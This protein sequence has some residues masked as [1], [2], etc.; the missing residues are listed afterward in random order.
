MVVMTQSIGFVLRIV[1]V[2]LLLVSVAACSAT[3]IAYGQADRLIL[4]RVDDLVSLT[5]EQED[6]L[7]ARID[8]HLDWHCRTQLPRY[9]QWLSSVRATLA[10]VPVAQGDVAGLMAEAEVFLDELLAEIAPTVAGLMLRLDDE[11]RRELFESLGEKVAESREEHL[12]PAVDER[13]R[14]RVERLEDRLDRWL[15]EMSPAQHEAIVR[16]S[17]AR[18][19]YAQAWLANRER[20]GERLQAAL[21]AQ[22]APRARLVSLV[23]R[24]DTVYTPDYA[25]QVERSRVQAI[26]LAVELLN[27]SSDAQTRKLLA[28]VDGLIEDARALSCVAAPATASVSRSG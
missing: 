12:E 2:A 15:G 3:R 23:E 27:L 10:E 22:D 4:W 7:R 11:Q 6:W 5:G 8:G 17:A 1:L 20:F 18:D 24:P 16:W 14:N 19:G 26:A 21:N 25:R 28:E 13:R 9:E